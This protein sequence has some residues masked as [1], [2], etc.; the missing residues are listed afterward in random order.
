M[1]SERLPRQ[2][3]HYAAPQVFQPLVFVETIVSLLSHVFRLPQGEGRVEG[4]VKSNSF[5]LKAF[6]T[7]E[8]LTVRFD[9]THCFST[10]ITEFLSALG[11]VFEELA[12]CRV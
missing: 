9:G 11:E 1:R 4:I 8:N 6:N 10:G 5:A 12:V 7:C 3:G 2:Q